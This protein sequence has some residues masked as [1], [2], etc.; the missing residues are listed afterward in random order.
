MSDT[1]DLDDPEVRASIRDQL[2]KMQ[3]MVVAL[4]KIIEIDGGATAVSMWA[5]KALEG[6]DF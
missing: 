4:Q 6:K 2:R 1:N 5:R 3:R